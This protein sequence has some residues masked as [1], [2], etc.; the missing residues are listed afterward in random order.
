MKV[1]VLNKDGKKTGREVELPKDI[2]EVESNDHV[3]Y[4]MVKHYN[5]NQRHGTSKAKER[6]EIK[7]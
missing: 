4:L 7:V 6:G 1:A 3:L 5:A 2:F